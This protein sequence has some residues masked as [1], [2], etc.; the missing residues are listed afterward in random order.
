M[1][2]LVKI[3]TF[4]ALLH[5]AIG[6]RPIDLF[7]IMNMTW[8]QLTP[9]TTLHNNSFE[10]SYYDIFIG[11]DNHKL[12]L[13]RWENFNE[14][15]PS[16]PNLTIRTHDYDDEIDTK[17]CDVNSPLKDDNNWVSAESVKFLK[18]DRVLISWRTEHKTE[19]TKILIN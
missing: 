11:K 4:H 2:F 5:V 6:Q 16:K 12:A 13:L 15:Y 18:S 1:E 10:P 3:I 17:T 7:G 19:G 8:T 14:A 9:H